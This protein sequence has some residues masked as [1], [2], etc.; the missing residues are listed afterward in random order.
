[1]GISFT[2]EAANHIQRGGNI[3]D[4]FQ[5]P[6]TVNPDSPKKVFLDPKNTGTTTR[7]GAYWKFDQFG[8]FHAA[9]K[10][11]YDFSGKSEIQLYGGLYF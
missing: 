1:V 3:T 10:Y 9:L 2:N 11:E 6:G 7:V 4:V 8:M 5:D